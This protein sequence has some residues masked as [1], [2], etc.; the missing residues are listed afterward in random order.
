MNPIVQQ[1]LQQ[2]AGGGLS[3]LS[4]RIG[5]DERTTGSALATIVPILISALA[6]NTA[7]PGGA[8][9]L[10][11]ALA[12]DHDGSILDNLEGFLENP[13][14]ANGAGILR[15][16][17]GGRQPVVT[18]ALT[19]GT[20]LNGD[21]IGQLMQIAAPLL[22]GILGRQQRSSGLDSNA[23]ATFLGG[24]RQS[25]QESNPDAMGVLGRLLDSDNDG[26]ATDDILGAIG[27]LFGGR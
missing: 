4:N 18:N 7:G 11:Q 19:R 20:N 5:S 21:Q 1:L 23:L 25:V 9:E 10:H 27:K 3:S 12:E 24:Q 13:Q 22:M 16:V 15:H 17:L 2:L 14:A 26:S 6:K 8:D